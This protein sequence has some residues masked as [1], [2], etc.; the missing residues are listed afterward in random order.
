MGMDTT[1]ARA[2][3][4]ATRGQSGSTTE[5]PVVSLV[6]RRGRPGKKTGSTASDENMKKEETSN[7]VARRGRS[8]RMKKVDQ[9]D[10]QTQNREGEEVS[11][12]L[13]EDEEEEKDER[14]STRGSRRGK[15]TVTAEVTANR[16][17][18][19]G[20]GR[21]KEKDQVVIAEEEHE[22]EGDSV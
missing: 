12:D 20:R 11:V 7:T 14:P 13:E 21:K 2:S 16:T 19:A 4:G 5:S 8:T 22:D 9:Q 15:S 10:S 1:P 6:T 18:R 3:R 17:T